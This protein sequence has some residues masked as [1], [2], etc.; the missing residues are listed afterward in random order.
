[1]NSQLP[2]IGALVRFGTWLTCDCFPRAAGSTLVNEKFRLCN[3]LKL[4]VVVAGPTKSVS[5]EPSG[6]LMSVMRNQAEA[7]PLRP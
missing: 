2:S 4:R 7:N 1:M 6:W 5:T 3:T